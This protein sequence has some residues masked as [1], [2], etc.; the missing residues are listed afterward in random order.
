MT[1]ID[2]YELLEITKSS[3]KSTIKKAYRRMAMKF[4]PDKNPGDYKAEEKFKAVNEAYQILSDESKREVYDRYGKAGLEGHGQQ[5]GGFGGFED[6]S[7]IFEDMFQG[8]G[9]G[10][11]SRHERKTYNYNLDVVVE[12][13]IEF[14]EAIFGAKK[15]IKYTYKNACKDCKGTGAKSGKLST[16]THCNGQGQVHMKQGFMTFAQTCPHCNGQGRA[17][18]TKCNTCFATG[19]KQIQDKFEVNIPE[20]V[21]DGN[22]IRVSNKGNI[23]PNGTRG[24]LY[25]QIKAKEDSHFIRHDDD[26]YIEVPIFF[27]QVA[28]GAS[29]KIPGLR[30]KLKLQI[31]AGAKDQEQFK[32]KNEGV[33]SVKGYGKGD[34]IVQIKIKYPKSVNNEQKELLEKLQD[35]FGV[36]SKP[37]ESNFEGMFEK[38]KKW[39]S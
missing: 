4:H 25:L 31:P 12:V 14:N 29:I 22:R 39:F 19:Y 34:L 8:G 9:F 2:Y 17:A 7:S 23:A 38:V 28:L 11:S 6:L 27:T 37:H 10:G 21:N 35:T 36:E 20:G 33:T 30:G 1:E 32:F 18:T 3:D 15:E 5:R 26:I 16:C 24:D 13:S